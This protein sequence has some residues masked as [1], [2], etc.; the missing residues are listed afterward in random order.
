[1]SRDALTADLYNS[2]A[3]NNLGVIFLG[4]GELSEAAAEFEW[5][6]S[7]CPATPTRG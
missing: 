2:P 7:S 1:L 6:A 5:A 4:R 3:C